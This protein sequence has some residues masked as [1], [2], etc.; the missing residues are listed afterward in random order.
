MA[1]TMVGCYPET[2]KYKLGLATFYIK[3]SLMQKGG[4]PLKSDSFIVI[5]EYYSEFMQFENESPIY[6]PKARL[7]FPNKKGDFHI[8]FNLKAA[9]INLSFIA[10]GY[11]FHSFFFRRQIGVGDIKYDV[12]LIKSESWN[13]EFFIQTRPFL[14]KFIL[15]QRYIMPDSQQIF[16][17]NWIAE[18]KNN[19][20]NK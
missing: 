2:L 10:A 4:E 19:L 20:A 13:N 9:S 3:G 8:N 15:E 1:I 11:K 6:I 5:T 16:I 14:E 18:V 7:V 17:G 12:E